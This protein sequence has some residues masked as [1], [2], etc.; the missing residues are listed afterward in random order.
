MFN[1]K[2]IRDYGVTIGRLKTG[3][4]NAISDVPGVMVGHATINNQKDSKTGVTAIL[5]HTGNLFKEKLVSANY[6][7]NGFGK[8]IGLVQIDELGQIETPILLTNTLNVGKVSDALIEYMLKDNEDIGIT[9]GTINPIVCECNDAYLNSARARYVEKHHVLEALMNAK[10]EFLEG[11]IGAGK[12]MK[13]YGYKGG[14]G[15]SSRIVTVN[16]NNYTVGILVLSNFGKKEDLIING[17]TNSSANI[18][19][20]QERGSIIFIVATDAPLSSRQLKRVIK[21]VE[22]GLHRTGSYMGNGSG[23]VAVG[24]TTANRVNHYEHNESTSLKVWNESKIDLLFRAVAE[25]T[26][27][28]ILNS[29]IT[30]ETVIGR[31]DHKLESLKYHIDKYLK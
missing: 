17:K 28:A 19:H 21:R 10:E 15:T 23:E 25:S 29:M 7:I 24:F 3:H 8:S 31:D 6:I 1:Q 30:A 2:R 4:R 9:T 26:E 13:C 14:I 16:D 20:E 27:E 11:D 22:V 18:D 12:G 5:P